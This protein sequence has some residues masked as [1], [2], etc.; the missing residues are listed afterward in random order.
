MNKLKYFGVITVIVEWFGV[1]IALRFID[2]FNFNNAISTLSVAPQPLALI[3]SITITLASL[4]FFLYALSLREFSKYIPIYAFIAS[5]AF[6]ILGWVPLTGD[7]GLADLLHSVCGIIAT[8]GYTLII[9]ECRNHPKKH[10]GKISV[11]VTSLLFL[12][13]IASILSLYVFH[14][15]IAVVEVLIVVSMQYWLIYVT[16]HSRPNKTKARFLKS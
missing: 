9:W 4:S 2:N 1:L 12:I 10:V 14:K 11:L 7:G 8:I 13:M 15:Y 5:M 6:L 3:F 16:W